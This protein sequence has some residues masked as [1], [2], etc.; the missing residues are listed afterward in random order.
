MRLTVSLL[1]AT[2]CHGVLFGVAAAVLSR[3]PSPNV[4]TPQALD[5]EIL[6][7][8]PDPIAPATP[9]SVP[10]VDRA[11]STSVLRRSRTLRR[12]PQVAIA[13]QPVA[14]VE[15]AEISAQAEPTVGVAQV[16][17]PARPF[18]AASSPHLI[19]GAGRGAVL[20]AKPRYRTNPTPEYPIA[21]RRRR[22]EG[23]VLLNVAVDVSGTPTAISLNRSSGY[24]LLDR[25]ALDAVR[26]WTFEPARSGGVAM[27][28]LVVVPVRFSLEDR[29]W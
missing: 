1:A 20:T 12:P 13:S 21:S 10:A 26:R 22:E 27:L 14:A 9:A 24:P 3:L 17:A 4:V 16:P 25:A 29:R 6:A 2:L 19:D 15:R 7:A 5:V 11:P 8:T 23:V 18:G 28:S